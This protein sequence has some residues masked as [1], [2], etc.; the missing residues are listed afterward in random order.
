MKISRRDRDFILA[1]PLTNNSCL[2]SYFQKAWVNL[3]IMVRIKPGS[4]GRNA[5]DISYT[6]VYARANVSSYSDR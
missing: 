6:S 5:N 4:H 3:C 1:L 2:R